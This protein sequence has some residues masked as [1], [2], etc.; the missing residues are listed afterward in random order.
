[1]QFDD[2][3][4]RLRKEITVLGPS[5][6]RQL[7]IKLVDPYGETVDLGDVDWSMTFEITTVTN[8][9][10]YENLAGAFGRS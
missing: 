9:V 2:G 1:M 5:N 3:A 6:V 7:R 10:T 8:S 4:N